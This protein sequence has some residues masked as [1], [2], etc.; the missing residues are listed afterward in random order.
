MKCLHLKYDGG[1]YNCY[2]CDLCG[3]TFDWNNS[4]VECVC[5]K[6]DEYK[7]CPIWKKYSH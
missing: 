7:N 2:R 5:K 4:T 3:K 6:D 1:N